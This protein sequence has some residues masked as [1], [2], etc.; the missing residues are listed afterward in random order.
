MLNVGGSI[1][2]AVELLFSQHL[3]WEN[4]RKHGRTSQLGTWQASSH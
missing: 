4:E 2:E 3:T 1:C